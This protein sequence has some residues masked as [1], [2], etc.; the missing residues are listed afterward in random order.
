ML[1]NQWYLYQY[2]NGVRTSKYGDYDNWF[3]SG[4]VKYSAARNLTL[5]LGASQAIRRQDYA[6]LA[7]T[8]VVNTRVAQ[9]LPSDRP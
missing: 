5:Q 1:P 2:H 7:G 3:W 8:I 4:G 6:E 9:E